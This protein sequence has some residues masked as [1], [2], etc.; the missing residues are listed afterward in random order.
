MNNQHTIHWNNH[1]NNSNVCHA[2]TAEERN[3]KALVLREM[4]G[5]TPAVALGQVLQLISGDTVVENGDKVAQ[6]NAAVCHYAIQVREQ[7]VAAQHELFV[8]RQRAVTESEKLESM[9]QLLEQESRHKSQV[10][11]EL[12]AYREHVAEI[13]A[14]LEIE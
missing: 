5:E 13:E 3:Q 8:A 6:L 2:M 1:T 12:R 14:L 9:T 10:A 11:A 7:L 4:L